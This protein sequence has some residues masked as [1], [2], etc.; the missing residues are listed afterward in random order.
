MVVF[1]LKTLYLNKLN[2]ASGV[3]GLNRD[4]VHKISVPL[5]PLAEQKCIAAILTDQLAA[6]ERARKAS[7]ARLEAAR[8]L[9][10]AYLREVFESENA[11]KWPLKRL[12]DV[13]LSNGQYGT[14]VKSNYLQKGLPVL[15]MAN[16]YDGRIRWNN[17]SH[18]VLEKKSKTSSF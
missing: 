11:A 2:K 6:V 1:F 5:P 18:V 7:E 8:A 15:G 4:D 10:A 16:I 12:V 14:S 13:C 17:I 9:P 3:P